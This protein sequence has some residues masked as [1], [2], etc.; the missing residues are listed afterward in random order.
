MRSTGFS[1]VCA[2]LNGNHVRVPWLDDKGNIQVN[3]GYRIEFNSAIGRTRA[4][5]GSTHGLPGILKFLAF[6]QILRT[7]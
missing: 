4:A 1:S 7:R 6:E 2:S 3:R 5:C